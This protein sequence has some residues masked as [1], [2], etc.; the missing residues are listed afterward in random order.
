MKWLGQYVQSLPT[1]FHNNVSIV[2]G[3]VGIGTASPSSLLHIEQSEATA[4][5]STVVDGQKDEGCTLYINNLNGTSHS[6]SQILFGHTND[7]SVSRI[8]SHN[9]GAN[10]SDLAFVVENSTPTEAMRIDA[11]GNVGIGTASPDQLLDIEASGQ[12]ATAPTIRISN[13]KNDGSWTDNHAV[14]GLEFYSTDGSGDNTAGVKA[15]LRAINT[16]GV[17]GGYVGLQFNIADPTANDREVMRLDNSGRLGI[18]N[19]DPQAKLDVTG[20][21]IVTGD[22]INFN[23][24]NADD[25]AIYINNTTNDDQA[26]RLIFNKLRADD[27][28]ASGQN[29]GEIWFSGQ[30][31]Q[32]AAGATEELQNYAYV[33]GEI[34]VSTNGEESGKLLLG[35]A[36]DDGGTGA[37]LILTGGS[38]DNEI[39]VTLGLGADSLTTVSGNLTVAGG[40]IT[41]T[42]AALT[43]SDPA[44]SAAQISTS[45]VI[46][47]SGNAAHVIFLP[48]P[49]VGKSVRIISLAAFELRSSNPASIAINGGTAA[50]AESAIAANMIVDCVCTTTTTWVCTQTN[51]VGVQS[52]V[53]VAAT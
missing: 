43:A 6:F 27:A 39:D 37:G 53:Q 51:S 20:N 13:T 18:G 44:S 11:N 26:S 25:P 8:V 35:V 14:G 46:V 5:D 28:V 49:V 23:S 41:I 22:T 45:V 1:I 52:A 38:E 9:Q 19:I 2:G 4:Y 17:Y 32:A 42:P 7:T 40:G 47:S 16:N 29:L 24:A 31:G 10:I 34:D 36:N 12:G 33:I 3:N 30:N 50:N 21:V 15:S 48:S